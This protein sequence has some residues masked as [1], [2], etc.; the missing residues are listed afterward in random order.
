MVIGIFIT[1][2]FGCINV[3]AD[4]KTALSINKSC[5]ISQIDCGN[6]TK[7]V[8]FK[9]R[10]ENSFVEY[11][12][13]INENELVSHRKRLNVG[14]RK[15]CDSLNCE[16]N[17]QRECRSVFPATKQW[18]V[19]KNMPKVTDCL[20][21]ASRLLAQNLAQT[22][23]QITRD[24]LA[25][26]S[27]VTLA[28]NGSNGQT[29]TN[30]TQEDIDSVVK[31][32]LGNDALM[33]SEVVTGTTQIGT[34][35][36]R[37]AFW[38]FIDTALLDDLESCS[39]FVSSSNYPGSQNVVLDAEWGST[40]NVRWLYTSVGSVSSASPAVYNNFIVGQEAYAVINLR[41]ETGE[42]YIKP[43]GSAG[44]ADPLNQRGSVG[45]QH[46]FTA[47]ILN[48][49]FMNNLMATHS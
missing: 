24:V 22:M 12:Y 11:S 8:R 31:T 30:L 32:L 13:S 37:P 19:G 5:Q 43:L 27:S 35:P 14:I 45:W 36:I 26:T 17:S 18:S 15:E 23:D 38:G 1:C 48:D 16:G 25:S 39:G 47:R 20:N 2:A 46:P 29:P 41:S 28:S 10:H 44:A 33:I 49:A 3:M 21:E 42:F 34:T 9:F 4:E 6:F 7:I 40:K